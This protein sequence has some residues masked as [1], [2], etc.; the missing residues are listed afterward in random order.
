MQNRQLAEKFI[1]GDRKGH[2]GH[3]FIDGPVIYSYGYHFPIA[4]PARR[5]DGGPELYLFNHAKYSS[6]T[7]RHESHVRSAIYQTGAGI[8]EVSTHTIEEYINMGSISIETIDRE[9][10]RIDEE[11][12]EL[13][14]KLKRARK[15]AYRE[16]YARDIAAL[17]VDK[18]L[19]YKI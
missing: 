11:I 5:K 1:E 17:E 2:T 6:T 3:M 16:L 13:R 8:L 18:K 4:T 10:S 12:E 9:V 7:Q 15:P 19:L 14:G